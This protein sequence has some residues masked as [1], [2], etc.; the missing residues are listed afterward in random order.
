M[1]KQ[2][3]NLIFT[4]ACKMLNIKVTKSQSGE[5]SL[6]H[7]NVEVRVIQEKKCCFQ[8][9]NILKLLFT[10][11]CRVIGDTGHISVTFLNQS[12]LRKKNIK[13]FELQI[14]FYKI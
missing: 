7:P 9:K 8:K 4:L 3:N 6:L 2:K 5:N 13:K 11:F 14:F 12:F 1:Q 10:I